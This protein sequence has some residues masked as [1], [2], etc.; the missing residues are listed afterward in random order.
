MSKR[1]FL[2]LKALEKLE[3]SEFPQCGEQRAGEVLLKT[4]SSIRVKAVGAFPVQLK[5]TDA[6]TSSQAC[7]S[8]TSVPCF[9][10]RRPSA[11]PPG[12]L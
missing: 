4:D 2:Q 8:D 11:L 6:F 12:F 1:A 5:I 10:G 9:R 7:M 3:K